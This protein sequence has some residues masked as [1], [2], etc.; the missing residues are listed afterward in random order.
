VT[1]LF[2]RRGF[3]IDSLAVG[4]TDN[5]DV[6][7]I[8]IVADGSENILEQ[9]E[10][11]VSKLF[12]VITVRSYGSDEIVSRELMFVKVN[13]GTPK[14]RAEIMT[15]AEILKAQVVDITPATMTLEICDTAFHIQR[16]AELV[17]P[18]GIIETVR[19]GSVAIEKGSGFVR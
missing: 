4:V 1:G 13:A 17:T 14:D 10:K 3:N 7:R 11:Q 19:T 16:F 2:S 12:E 15:V 18:Y 9:I 8:T 6:S 5:P